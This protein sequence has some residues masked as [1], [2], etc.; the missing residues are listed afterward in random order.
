MVDSK[1]QGIGGAFR[2]WLPLQ[3]VSLN[4]I[5]AMLDDE[6]RLQV[7]A[8]DLAYLGSLMAN[9]CLQKNGV[10]LSAVQVG[11]P[12]PFF[13]A[14]ENQNDFLYFYDCEYEGRDSKISSIEGC[15]SLLDKTGL[16]RRF[17]LSRYKTILCKGKKVVSYGDR[18]QFEDCEIEYDGFM[19][20]VLQHEIDHNHFKLIS[21]LGKEIQII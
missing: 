10:G 3:I 14:S 19:S 7:T 17:L 4:E 8:T 2:K 18:I 20:I 1:T 15:L 12:L 13:V 9:L 21:E 16:T 11:I 5:P 6:L